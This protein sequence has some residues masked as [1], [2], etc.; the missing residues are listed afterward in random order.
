MRLR[1]NCP[2]I[3]KRGGSPEVPPVDLWKSNQTSRHSYA[4]AYTLRRVS[5]RLVED[6][7]IS[8]FNGYFQVLIDALVFCKFCTELP[9][10][11]QVAVKWCRGLQLRKPGRAFQRNF[12]AMVL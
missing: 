9:M 10:L 12:V 2:C 8:H 7:H 4:I 5:L 6:L 11:H 3:L 1:V